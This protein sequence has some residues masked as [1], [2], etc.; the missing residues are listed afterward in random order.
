MVRYCV[1]VKGIVQGV[2]FR[3]FVF[4]LAKKLSLCGFVRNTSEGVSI[5]IEGHKDDCDAF[6]SELK[7]NPPRL[8]YIEKVNSHVIPPEGEDDFRILSSCEG[9]H[10]TFI[11]PDIG[12][13]DDCAGDIAAQGNRRYRYAFTNCTNCGPRFTIVCDI[14]YDRKNTTMADFP[15]CPDCRGEYEN[16]YD[17]RFHAQPNACPVCGPHLSFY[18]GGEILTRDVYELFNQSIAQGKIVAL[19]GI[20]GFH[21]AC[22]AKNEE[23]V[24]RLRERKLRFDK[25]FAVMMR[26]IETVRKYCEFSEAEREVLTSPEKPIVLLKKKAHCS[27]APST[28][29]LNNRL[30]VMLPYTP[31]HCIL[32]QGEEAL[33]M[34]SGNI[35]DRPMIFRDDE[36][37]SVLPQIADAVLTHNRRIFRRMDDSVCIIINNKTHMLRRARGYVPEPFF[38]KGNKGVILALGAQ[39]KNTFCLA[40]GESA[41][42]S[43][44]IGDLDDEDT[45][46]CLES[47]T[48]SFIRIFDA[49]PQAV[50]CDMHPDYV[51]T[52]YASRYRGVVPII[53]VQHHHAHFASVLAEHGVEDDN[54][55]GLIFDG[56]GYGEDGCV[57]GG[58]ALLGN[59]KESK[60]VGH[61]LYFPLPGGEAAIKEPWRT[62]LAVTDMAAGRDAALSLFPEYAQESKLLLQA[63]DRKLNSPLTSSMGRLFD[64]VA[65]LTGVRTQTTFEGQA[66]IDLQQIMD[67]TAEGSYHFELTD[68]K[69][70]I[71]FDW[72]PLIREILS[73]IAAGIP[74]GEISLRFHCAVTELITSVAECVRKRTGCRK[75]ALS[76]GVFQND[77]LLGCALPALEEM[78]FTVYTNEKI[79]ANDGGISF[80]QAASASYKMR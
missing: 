13:C 41:F 56:T 50:A 47:E 33:V 9:T 22:D 15:L 6:I 78:G 60:R 48:E 20:G 25:P 70:V 51:S 30:G 17:R 77:Y 11:S 21:L 54:V 61:A 65:A 72:R 45:C 40:K 49:E 7:A 80:G 18:T 24:N 57:W 1:E 27:I 67:G 28:T 52:I 38:I 46:K 63:G 43:G 68:E 74:A 34:T 69:G 32:M 36:A 19:K 76:G 73:D 8:A 37:L 66:A 59:I 79:P 42:L 10:D 53:A 64:A 14:P 39:Q 62:A 23:A 12:I 4:R 5:E 3:P 16:P 44:H 55:L 71:L 31:L 35:S 58:E 29:M 2:G 26:D 75:A